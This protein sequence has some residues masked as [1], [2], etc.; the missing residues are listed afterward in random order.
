MS[1]TTDNPARTFFGTEL[2]RRRD[3]A[4][5]TG[6]Q[7]ADSLGCT[8]QWISVMEGGKKISE[9]SAHD[10]DTYF[11]TGGLFHR[12]WKLANDIELQ[13]TL[14]PGF[15]EYAEREKRANSIRVYSAILLTGLF[16][17]EDYAHTVMTS[18]DG[19]HS[20][21]LVDKRMER[22][23]ILTRDKAPH[24]W[25]TVDE[26]ILR[27][28]V[29]SPEVMRKQLAFLLE[30]SELPNVMVDVVPQ[31][32]GYYAGLGGSFNLLGFEDGTSSAYTESAGVGM[33]IEQPNK[34]ALFR[35]RYD[36][37]RGH[38]LPVRESRALI[39]AVLE[40]L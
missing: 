14:P 29:G 17:T 15:P 31:S 4:G 40:E 3:E 37:L 25:L 8:P 5:L 7:L 2:R 23:A 39:Q 9:Q 32:V 16:Q 36:L 19:P 27:R 21:D 18:T 12:L 11:K 26:T 22:K 6:K 1:T 28:T 33:L 10:L 24:V 30:V 20:A 38:A 35:I 13:T 34:V